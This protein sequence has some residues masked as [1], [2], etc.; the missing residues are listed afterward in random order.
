MLGLILVA[1]TAEACV[2]PT[3]Y[4]A[5]VNGTHISQRQVTRELNALS[6][7]PDFVNAYNQAQQ[8]SQTGRGTVLTANTANR[9]YSQS[10][11]AAVLGLD[12]QAAVVH[13]EVVKRKLTVSRS[14]ID[15]PATVA[16]AGQQFGATVFAKFPLWLRRLFQQRQAEQDALAAALKPNSPAVDDAAVTQFY[17]SHLQDFITSQCVSH[18]LVASQ[19]QAATIVTQLQ[20]GADFATLATQ[21]STDTTTAS[22][23]GALG[24]GAPGSGTDPVSTDQ[25]FL[26][27]VTTA[28]TD[29]VSGPVQITQGWDVFK[30]TQRT[31]SPLTA[32]LKQIIAQ[33]LQQQAASG[34]SQFFQNAAKTLHVQIN[35]V[36]GRWDT[37]QLAVVAPASPDPAKSGLPTAQVAPAPAPAPTTTTVP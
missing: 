30:V 36:Y 28:P 8:S 32:Q 11:A 20:A 5:I 37:Q 18:I 29:T 1:L 25:Q 4:A 24:C 19:Q 35:P 9:A 34:L 14:V 27:A 17:N 2:G 12:V 6:S 15:D 26:T 21:N 23:G 3:P 13:A 10:F 22:K 7:N 33:Q 16:A 31:V